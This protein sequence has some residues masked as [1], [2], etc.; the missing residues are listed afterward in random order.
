VL[1]KLGKGY[2][3]NLITTI[4]GHCKSKTYDFDDSLNV[5]LKDF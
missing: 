3:A 4:V 5:L 2:H 1:K